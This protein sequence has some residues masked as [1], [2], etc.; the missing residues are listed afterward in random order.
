[1]TAHVRVP[2]L[3]PRGRPATLSGPILSGILR[4]QMGYDGVIMT[5]SLTMA[6]VRAKYR[7]ERVPVMALKAGADILADPHELPL[8]FDAVMRAVRNGDIAE[9]R[10][11]RS[12]ERV[13]RL[14]ER[15]G[16]LDEPMVEVE[17]VGALL[18]QPDHDAVAQAVGEAAITVLRDRRDRLP[19]PG[20]ASI[21]LT[22]A[23][24][25]GEG[26]LAG[27]LRR[28]G[29]EVD[30]A[31][32][33]LD[34][35]RKQVARAE[36]A[37]RRNDLTVVVTRHLGPHPK[38]RQLVRR[39]LASGARV[40][41]VFGSSP[42]DVTW[43]PDAP[44]QVLT[45]STVPAVM[46]GLAGVLSGRTEVRGTLPV[47]IPRPGGGGTLYPFGHGRGPMADGPEDP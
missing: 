8:A 23:R 32:T 46:R 40:I 18:G 6:G 33:G 43:F 41:L 36:R 1:M 15:L 38:Q 16:L 39:V 45:Y 12:V 25:E 47:R 10:I 30:T 29:Y 34:P 19:L 28:M 24:P 4:E 37:A 11:D 22:G 27:S 2:A 14:K 3:D 7:D 20:G 9:D 31:W 21:A 13:L 42:Y 5:D 26:A 17:A 35:S 44:T